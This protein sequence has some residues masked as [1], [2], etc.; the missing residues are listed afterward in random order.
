MNITDFIS[1]IFKPFADLVDNVHTSSEEKQTLRNK[2]AEINAA[3]TVKMLE[4]EGQIIEAQSKALVAEI[5]GN[6]WLQQNWRPLTMVTFVVL[7]VATWSGYSAPGLTEAM[8]LRLLD[9]VEIGLG[10]YVLGRSVEKVAT[11]LKDSFK[12]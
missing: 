7:V 12:K 5:Q 10:G 11:T 4:L 1:G 3:L 9:I 6:S 8:H 2:L